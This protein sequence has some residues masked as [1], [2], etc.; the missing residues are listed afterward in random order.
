MSDERELAPA[1]QIARP[2]AIA[3]GTAARRGSVNGMCRRHSWKM[4]QTK[5]SMWESTPKGIGCLAVEETCSLV[6]TLQ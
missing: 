2:L 6:H 3:R 4:D 1:L 5:K